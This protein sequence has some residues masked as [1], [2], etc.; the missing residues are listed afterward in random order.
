MK[1]LMIAA[2]A[3]AFASPAIAQMEAGTTTTPSS[4]VPTSPSSTA[5]TPSAAGTPSAS[6]ATSATAATPT[7]AKVLIATEFPSYDKDA[8]GSLDQT[9]FA[10]W[11][12]ALKA[13]N[14]EPAMSA[15]ARTTYMTGA[16]ATADK[17]K[18]KSVSLSELQTYLTAGA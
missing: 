17:D 2:S 1:Y 14:G 7:D 9:E 15:S 11:M 4:T 10:T 18:S 12:G 3:L 5:Q 8:N 16:F 13:K 6:T